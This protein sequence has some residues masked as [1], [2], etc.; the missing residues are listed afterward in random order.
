[1]ETGTGKTYC[2]IKTIYEMKSRSQ[3]LRT[4]VAEGL[5]IADLPERAK[6]F[7]DRVVDALDE[8]RQRVDAL[9]SMVA[10]EIWPVPKYSEM[11]FIL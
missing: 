9:E 3:A 11:L 6:F 5:A 8:V 1:M 4:T 7:A 10:D 2:Y